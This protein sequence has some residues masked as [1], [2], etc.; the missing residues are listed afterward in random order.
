MNFFK[1]RFS[2]CGFDPKREFLRQNSLIGR[3]TLYS[4]EL[5]T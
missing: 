4:D 1:T 5:Q 2:Q 3:N